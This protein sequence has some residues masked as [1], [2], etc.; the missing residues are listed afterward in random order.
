MSNDSLKRDYQ[1]GGDHYAS[2]DIQ[3][4]DVIDRWPMHE[5]IGFHRGNAMKYLLR[6][7][8][9]RPD[10]AAAPLEDAKKALHYATK[11]VATLEGAQQ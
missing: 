6:F 11:L 5:Q 3:P 7:G 9:K 10:D 8:S 1:V 2:M 4:W